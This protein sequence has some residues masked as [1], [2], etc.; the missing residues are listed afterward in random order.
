MVGN[1][2]A[3]GQTDDI[4]EWHVESLLAA[5]K[6]P[7]I[8]SFKS[9]FFGGCINCITIYIK[10]FL[11]GSQDT[12][13]HD[14]A[15]C[16]LWSHDFQICWAFKRFL[17]SQGFPKYRFS[18]LH[19]GDRKRFGVFLQS[20]I[21]SNCPCMKDTGWTMTATKGRIL[22]LAMKYRITSWGTEAVIQL[23]LQMQSTSQNHENPHLSPSHL[24]AWL[25]ASVGE[26]PDHIEC[27]AAPR[28]VFY[29]L[30]KLLIAIL[31]LFCC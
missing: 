23:L 14:S 5:S 27:V 11:F 12:E 21:V 13:N 26:W 15:L 22:L 9:T 25:T 7:V 30:L 3:T 31:L 10:P 6:K 19:R 20:C 2:R 4:A 24:I 1:G 18:F 16:L 28:C 29:Y 17:P 8:F